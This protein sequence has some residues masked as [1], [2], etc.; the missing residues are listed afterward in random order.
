MEAK[1]AL[2]RRCTLLLAIACSYPTIVGASEV[3]YRMYG[4]HPRVYGYAPSAYVFP[5]YGFQ[6]GYVYITGPPYGSPELGPPAVCRPV[7]EMPWDFSLSKNSRELTPGVKLDVP[8]SALTDGR[9]GAQKNIASAPPHSAGSAAPSASPPTA[10]LN[11]PQNRP[12]LQPIPIQAAR[13]NPANSQ[14][15]SPR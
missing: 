14:L 5:R 8:P 1:L 7:G 2:M 3:W 10:G 11:T 15:Q 4:Y 13:A 6:R 12:P 9:S